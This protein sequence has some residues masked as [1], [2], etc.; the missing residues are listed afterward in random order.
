MD[1]GRFDALL[2]SISQSPSR[3]GAL[4]LLAS[5]VLVGHF[6]RGAP[7]AAA[8]RKTSTHKG[9]DNITICHNGRTITV[10]KRK[11]KRHLKHGDTRGSCSTAPAPTGLTPPAFCADNADGTECGTRTRASD[12]LRCCAGVCPTFTCRPGD[13]LCADGETQEECRA[14][15]CTHKLNLANSACARAEPTD[16]PDTYT[17]GGDGDCGDS[18]CMCGTCCWGQGSPA[19]NDRCDQCC[20]GQCAQ[21]EPAICV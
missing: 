17:C 18:L 7:S 14:A 19:P 8:K 10:A 21:G 12:K 9:K 15:C 3:R 16:D 1:A 11:L 20:S 4:R 6:S 5:S 13:T 2:R